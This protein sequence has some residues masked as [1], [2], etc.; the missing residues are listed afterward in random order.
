MVWPYVED[1][2]KLPPKAADEVQAQWQQETN[3]GFTSV[4]VRPRQLG[5]KVHA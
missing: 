2:Y 3:K 1:A 5:P 4:L